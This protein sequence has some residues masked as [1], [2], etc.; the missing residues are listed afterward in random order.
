MER[1]YSALR[2]ISVIYK[3]LGLL[4][5]AL[6]VLAA[7][8]L[9]LASAAGSAALGSLSQGNNPSLAGGIVGGIVIAMIA[10]LYGGFISLTLYSLGEMITLIINVEENTRATAVL[11]QQQRAAPTTPVVPAPAGAP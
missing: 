10:L 2:T 4:I 8:G 6:T 9:C 1:R 7:L 11:L 3:I 5:L